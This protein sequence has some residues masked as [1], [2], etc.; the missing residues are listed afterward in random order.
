MA[1]HYAKT[2]DYLALVEEARRALAAEY[3]RRDENLRPRD[4]VVAQ[5]HQDIN[6]NL[7]LADVHSS[8]A[9]AQRLDDVSSRME[10]ADLPV[11]YAVAGGRS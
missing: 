7:K 2:I 4:H 11:G 10:F 9:I 6:R 8:L 3:G 1:D 5:L